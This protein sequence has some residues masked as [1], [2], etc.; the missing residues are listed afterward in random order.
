ME[1]TVPAALMPADS[2]PRLHGDLAVWL[3]ILIEL[4]TFALLFASFA[5]ARVWEPQVFAQSQATLDLRFGAVNTMLLVSGSAGV[6]RA[7]QAL[8]A[9]AAPARAGRWWLFALACGV[10]FLALKGVEYADKFVA[11]VG[12]TTNTFYMFYILL[13]GFHFLHVLVGVVFIGAAIGVLKNNHIQVDFFYRHMPAGM[14]RALA[15][16]VDVLRTAFFAAAVVMTVQ[17]M[18]KIGNN[19][20]M[21]I[22]D[23]PMNIVYGV[24]LL[25]FVAMLV[26]SVQVSVVHWRRG[27]SV[28][29]RPETT[30]ADR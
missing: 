30:M 18:A 16:A 20:S 8:R 27:Y 1:Q 29:E 19:A 7:V 3:V 24:C 5:F 12:L 22:V 28:L 21:T 4:A 2:A 9:G 10:A 26:R 17:M 6:A 13:T 23:L 11:G 15:L 25:G 14:A